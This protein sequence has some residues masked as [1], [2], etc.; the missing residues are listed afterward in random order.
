MNEEEKPLRTEAVNFHGME[1]SQT[2]EPM[3]K[4]G[5]LFVVSTP[6]GNLEDMTL[7]G[8]KVLKS[9]DL[10]AAEGVEHSRSL[11]RH[12][13]I[14]TQVIGYN[15]HNQKRKGV[16]LISRLEAG[17]SVA[18]VT[19]A[20]TPGVSDPG[21]LLVRQAL[22]GGIRVCPI[23]GPSAVTAA[24]CV[25]GLPA[26]RFL[27]MGF[28]ATRSARRKRELES[29]STEGRTMVFFEAPHRVK[30]MLGDVF[31]VLGDRE[32]I[33]VREMTKVHE[34]VLRGTVRSVRDSLEEENTR[35]EFTL[36]I[37]GKGQKDETLLLTRVAQK[38]IEKLVEQNI[39]T[40]RDIAKKIAQ[41]EGLPWRR[42]YRE[43]LS[44][45]RRLD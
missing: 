25:S 19:N 43:C 6:L 7:R 3:E 23:P 33:V 40:L 26:E 18:L 12:Y 44:I 13:G 16:E 8:L 41:E 9:V 35:G 28:L 4:T 21:L 39:M 10:I 42:V 22:E 15:Q 11:C 36:V 30:E 20:G 5:T 32:I 38:R 31:E 1:C 37:A 34:Q 45:K 14:T 27:F 29:L 2:E 17:A 24:L